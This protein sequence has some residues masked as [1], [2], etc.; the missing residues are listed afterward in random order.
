MLLRKSFRNK[1]KQY[2]VFYLNALVS[3]STKASFGNQ[4]S[5][6]SEARVH[7][8]TPL[9]EYINLSDLYG[10][11]CIWEYNC[12]IASFVGDTELLRA[13]RLTQM[14]QSGFILS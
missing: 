12:L 13:L 11:C 2:V 8:S 4:E 3:N 6:V 1:S 5:L 9:V 14:Q 10:I 7:F